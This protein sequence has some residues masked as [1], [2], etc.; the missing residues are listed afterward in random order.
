MNDL[1]ARLQAGQRRALAR[2]LTIVDGDDPRRAE[3]LAALPPT[4]AA[5][6]TGITG[7]PGTGKST[8]VS[9]LT[10]YWRDQQ[11]T[12][13]ILAI[14]P[15]SPFSGGA[16]LGDR[17]RMS[18]HSGDTGVFVRS[19]ATR[20]QSGG[21]SL[22]ARDAVRVLSAAGFDQIVLETVGAGQSE[23]EVMHIADTTVVVEAPGLGDGVQAIKA[24]ILEIADVFAVNKAD[25]PGAEAV[26]NNLRSMLRLQAGSSVATMHH[27]AQTPSAADEQDSSADETWIPPVLLTSGEA[28]QGI[29]A[30]AEAIRAHAVMLR[31]SGQYLA[32]R[33]AAIQRELMDRLRI[34]LIQRLVA[35]V[36]HDM[37]SAAVQQI[38]RHEI[39][40][41]TAAEQII[42]HWRQSET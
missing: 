19:M 33:E 4:S 29:A 14:D 12:V 17:I 18:E 36:S 6:V 39:D 34:T 40:A 10:R 16:L 21:L 32:R 20:G 37:I 35:S 38:M 28:K 13:A 24:G 27:G 22:A 9:A 30:L 42:T 23:I 26:A 15:S 41:Q 5:W 11:Q 3:L 25:R 8:L 2:A 1:L 31:A 7:A